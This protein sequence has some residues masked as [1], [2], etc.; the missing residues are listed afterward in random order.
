MKTGEIRVLKQWVDANGSPITDPVALTK[1]P[2]VKV[3]LTK[4]SIKSGCTVTFKTTDGTIRGTRTI[5][6][7][8]TLSITE[9]RGEPYPW[10]AGDCTDP[11]AISSSTGGGPGVPYTFTLGPI[12]QDCEIIND[13]IGWKAN[14]LQESGGTDSTV[15]VEEPVSTVTLNPNN[16][17]S[18]LWTGLDTSKD[19][20]Y[21]ITEESV[22]GY[23]TTYTVKNGD[24]N[25]LTP[26]ALVTVTNTAEDSGGYTLPSTGGTGTTPFTAVGG[27]MALAALVCGACR[28]R[29][30]ERRSD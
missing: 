14:E 6:K 16:D 11:S 29:R 12:N 26:G 1:V 23:K 28:K 18:Y 2:E 9:W 22:T 5:K 7:G 13:T 30:R 25:K 17:W 24:I 3:T 27:A 8:A 21:T 19:V 4:H 20:Y 10:N 15:Q